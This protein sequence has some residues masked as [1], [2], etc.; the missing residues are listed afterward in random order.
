MDDEV[1]NALGPALASALD[2]KGYTELTPVQKAVLDPALEGRDLRITSQTGSGKTVAIGF[3]LRKIIEGDCSARDG[4]AR[5]KAMVVAPT[6]ELAKQV[7][8]ELSWLFAPSRVKIASATGGASI[9][10]ERRALAGG[11]AIVVGTPG[12]LLDHLDRGGI[13][14]TQVGAVVF[15]EADRML[16]LGFREDLEKIIG[17]VPEEH[18]T[19]LCSATFPRDVRALA[20]RVQRDPAHVE[21]TRLGVAN[22]DIDHVVHLVEFRQRI[23]AIVNLLL[24]HPEAQTLVFAR[25]RADV[26]HIASELQQAGFV[27]NSLSGEM[28]QP[29]RDRAL[30]AFKRGNLDALVATD[31]AARGI[32]VQDIARVIHAEP[33]N[34]ADTYTHRSGRTGRAGRKGT[35]SV[36]VS[37]TTLMRASML[38]RRAGVVF[39]FEPI[40][41]AEEIRRS[42]DDRFLVAITSPDPEGFI[43]Y[44]ARTWEM[45]KHLSTT[46]DLVR[47]IAHLL[48]RARHGGAT[49]PREIRLIEPPNERRKALQSSPIGAHPSAK[50][51][52]EQRTDGW[53]HFRITWG[54]EHGADARRVLAMVCRRGQIQG[55]E[56]G[57]IKILRTYSIVEI[58]RDVADRFAEHASQPD[59]RNPRVS[60][61]RDHSAATMAKSPSPA[62]PPRGEGR[63]N[64]PRPR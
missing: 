62:A 57:A 52:R 12:R 36:L 43:G 31:V 35:S 61:K 29:E 47:T 8:E 44:D 33:P 18:Q 41:S 9:R 56:V 19:H 10:D 24:A 59:E 25:T 5:P 54:N 14:A 23:D 32:D 34:D 21:G 63:P 37:P 46:P 16:D 3:T 27:V 53:A 20:D 64:R 28:E 55:S 6:R 48:V 26:S 51:A 2:K 13:D 11:P 15:D 45:A 4:I 49:E 40:P 39:R 58:A 17:F 22:V 30:A 7:E 60:I 1:N 38:L 50:H 42:A